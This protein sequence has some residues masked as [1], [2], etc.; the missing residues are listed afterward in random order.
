MSAPVRYIVTCGDGV[1]IFD[2]GSAQLLHDLTIPANMESVVSSSAASCR[3]SG[4]ADHWTQWDPNEASF[5]C[6]AYSGSV[7]AAGANTP[8]LPALS[9]CG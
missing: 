1:H 8:S 2:A 5:R 6:V 4:A 7:L 3:G 9:L